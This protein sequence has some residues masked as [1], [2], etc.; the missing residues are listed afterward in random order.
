MFGNSMIETLLPA[1]IPALFDK[2]P[3]GEG[4]YKTE[5]GKTVDFVKTDSAFIMQAETW[6]LIVKK[7]GTITKKDL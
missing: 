2:L 7:D 5:D 6:Q 1:A 3:N 4:E